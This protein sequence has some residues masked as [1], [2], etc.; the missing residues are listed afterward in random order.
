MLPAIAAA[1]SGVPHEELIE[2]LARSLT[3]RSPFWL[4]RFVFTAA[5]GLADCMHAAVATPLP[6]E[7]ADR[8]TKYFTN[9][10]S[11]G[12]VFVFSAKGDALLEFEAGKRFLSSLLLTR[13][14]DRYLLVD[15][16]SS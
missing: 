16:S 4:E 3:K 8:L 9:S 2:S 12:Y 6:Y 11:C 10:D 15:T 5:V 7:D 1:T 14:F 13:L